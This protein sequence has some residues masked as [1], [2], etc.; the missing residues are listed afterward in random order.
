MLLVRPSC[1]AG[2]TTP[3]QRIR[4]GV[5]RPSSK[6][7]RLLRLVWANSRGAIEASFTSSEHK[8]QLAASVEEC[9]NQL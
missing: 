7:A 5:R 4:I 2:V 3:S 8:Q 9:L 6:G 1:V